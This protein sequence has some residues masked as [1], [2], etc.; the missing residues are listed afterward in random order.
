MKNMISG[1]MNKFFDPGLELPVQAF[2]LLACAGMAASVIAGLFAALT[3]LGAMPV[4]INA[5][6]FAVASSFMYFVHETK[7]H[8][9]FRRMTVVGV[10]II[11]FPALFFTSGG[12]HSGMPSY[13]VFALVFTTLMLDGR[14]RTAALAAEFLIYIGTCLIAY[15][16]PDLVMFFT[17]EKDLVVDV[18][19]CITVPGTLLLLVVL[20]YIRIHNNRQKELE[21]LNKLKT[22]FLQVIKHEIR[23]PLHVI[24]LG[25]DFLR[26]RMEADCTQE[27][28]NALQTIQNETMRLGRMINGMVE[29]ATMTSSSKKR[30]KMDFAAILNNCAEASRLQMKQNRNRLYVDIAPLPFVYA[31]SEQLELVPANLLT[32]AVNCTRDGEIALRA[33]VDKNYITVC[34]S[35]TGEGIPPELLPHVLERGVSGKGSKGYGLYICKTV[36]EAHGGSIQIDSRHGAGTTVTFTIPAYGGQG[37]EQE[38]E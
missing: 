11:A 38:C 12:Y 15:L 2:N 3:G 32:N 16:R 10:F 20:L 19:L 30:E 1:F 8:L 33:S 23:N 25:T 27:T 31:E 9:F 37:E 28:N 5:I 34:I 14:D 13:Y 24:S 21:E 22:E 17:S 6:L 4:I 35:D 18:I 7:H 26:N 36:V 29:L